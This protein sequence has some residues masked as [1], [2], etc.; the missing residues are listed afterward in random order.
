MVDNAN[1][2]DAIGINEETQAIELHI[3]DHLDFSNEEE[4]L[5][6]LQ[7]KLESYLA[8]VLNGGLED[9]FQDDAYGRRVYF[10]INFSYE[11]LSNTREFLEYIKLTLETNDIM[12]GWLVETKN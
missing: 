1:V 5:Q 7:A 8:Y 12:L 11:P 10:V 4:H 6:M 9:V 3:K 2:L